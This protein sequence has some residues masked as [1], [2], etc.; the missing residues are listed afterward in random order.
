M[1]NDQRSNGSVGHFFVVPQSLQDLLSCV[2]W[3]ISLIFGRKKY[4]YDR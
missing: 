4:F 3:E 1:K 2:E